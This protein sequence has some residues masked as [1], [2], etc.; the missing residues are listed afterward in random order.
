MNPTYYEGQV[1]RIDTHKSME[2]MDIVIFHPPSFAEGTLYLKRLVGL[3][4]EHIAYRNGKLY[5]NNK[6]V[7][8]PY[9]AKTDDFELEEEFGWD[10]IPENTYFFV[11][12]NRK[13]STDSRQFGSV[14]KEDIVGVV[15]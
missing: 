2:R 7:A 13:D 14:S 8:D 6:Q 15:K 1:V 5:I 12:D 10:V 9:S 11:G 3:P 4:G